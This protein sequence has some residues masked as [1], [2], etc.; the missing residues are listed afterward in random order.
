MSNLNRRRFVVR[1]GLLVGGLAAASACKTRGFNNQS[2]AKSD[3]LD[4]APPSNRLING[5][6][7]FVRFP[8]IP[9]AGFSN[10][11]VE[12]DV[13]N[14]L[15]VY[16]EVYQIMMSAISEEQAEITNESVTPGQ[17]AKH[18]PDRVA[19][20]TWKHFTWWNQAKIHLDSCP[21]G[22]QNFV[23]WHRP[24]LK[25]FEKT[26]RTIA[27]SVATQTPEAELKVHKEY[28]INWTLP[29]FNWDPSLPLHPSF[30]D[31][32]IF[33]QYPDNPDMGTGNRRTIDQS[34]RPMRNG[35]R[36][37]IDVTK[38]TVEDILN[39]QSIYSFG[40]QENFSSLLEGAPH[41]GVHV[42][43][44][45]QMG[46]FFSPLD[47]IFWTH[48][49]MIDFLFEEWMTRRRNEGQS[50][51]DFLPDTLA[52]GQQEGFFDVDTGLPTSMN[53]VNI[54]ESEFV[55]T[56]YFGLTPSIA[57][58]IGAAVGAAVGSGGPLSLTA[59]AATTETVV[60]DDFLAGFIPLSETLN[61]QTVSIMRAK[62]KVSEDSATESKALAL[63][64]KIA[65][66]MAKKQP[67]FINTVQIRFENIGIAIADPENSTLTIRMRK[68]AEK[69]FLETQF[70]KFN[71]FG[72]KATPEGKARIEK[73]SKTSHP[74]H[75][76]LPKSLL[77][78]LVPTI[79]KKALNLNFKDLLTKDVVTVDFLLALKQQAALNSTEGTKRAEGFQNAFRNDDKG[80]NR[81][82][83]TLVISQRKR[84]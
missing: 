77:I 3:D 31:P 37:F 12:R 28:Y 45:G 33:P 64:G 35:P 50:S 44:G 68:T 7:A 59:S 21:H 72:A 43:V 10:P 24:Y 70:A 47:P 62:L 65:A 4:K 22:D 2:K 81:I 76:M 73:Q 61:G 14:L 8:M 41:G 71:K 11:S 55:K 57:Y 32:S 54:V 17:L 66:D 13:R 51:A 23:F 82:K 16:G 74:E 19:D 56:S 18:L 36:D 69:P 27:R 78:D 58:T 40:G 25:H 63:L 49:G 26:V 75:H 9:T 30:F 39:M 60:I 42:W 15:A 53:N 20:G 80:A 5:N 84:A 38:E 29:F 67:Q 34:S 48:H 46:A 79:K 52:S 1:S 6:G 83:I